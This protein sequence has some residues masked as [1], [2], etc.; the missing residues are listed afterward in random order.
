MQDTNRTMIKIYR[1]LTEEQIK[2]NVV[3]SSCLSVDSDEHNTIHEVFSL[4]LSKQ[5]KTHFDDNQ[6]EI[7][8][9]KDDKFFNDSRFKYNII[10]Q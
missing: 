4:P 1:K 9:L 6:E 2:R 10:R 5:T 8:K 3:F 7:R